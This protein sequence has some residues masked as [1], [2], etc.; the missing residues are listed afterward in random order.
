MKHRAQWVRAIP[1]IGI[2]V[3]FALGLRQQAE[4]RTEDARIERSAALSF[5]A[6]S[7]RRTAVIR[8]FIYGFTTPPT[9]AQFD[10]IPDP[11]LRAAA[12][13]QATASRATLRTRAAETFKDRDCAAEFPAP[14][15]GK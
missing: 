13:E 8:E 1:Y 5:C 12:L 6:D 14:P 4:A 10:Y 9:P 3:L 2:V 15:D 7:N 11:V